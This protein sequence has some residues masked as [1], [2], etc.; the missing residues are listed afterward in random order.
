MTRT[1]SV[2]YLVVPAEPPYQPFEVRRP[3]SPRPVCFGRHPSNPG[4]WPFELAPR[5]V[6]SR[7]PFDTSPMA[8]PYALHV[9]VKGAMTVFQR[10]LVQ[11]RIMAVA[12][13]HG[14]GHEAE[15]VLLLE[16]A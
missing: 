12:C 2:P 3:V 4:D 8:C 5:L 7:S 1:K 16:R 14:P 10:K 6:Y 9:R 15:W 13:E 11:V